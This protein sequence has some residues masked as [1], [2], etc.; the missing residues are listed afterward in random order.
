VRE[1]IIYIKHP[2]IWSTSPSDFSSCP[3]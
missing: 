2:I 1:E 3:T